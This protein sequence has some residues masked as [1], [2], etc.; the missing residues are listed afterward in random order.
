[1]ATVERL[2]FSGYV[3]T[4]ARVADLIRKM[5]I[6]IQARGSGVGSVL[7]YALHTSSVE[8]IA[9]GLLFERFLSPE[10]QYLPDID[11][12]VESARRHDIYR[13]VFDFFGADR[14]SLMS[15]TNAY[16]GRGAVRDAGLAMGLSGD[17]IDAIPK[18][19]WRFNARDFRRALV[20]KP[21]LAELA[22]DVRRSEHL[23][24]LVD[25]TAK[26]DRLP[27]HFSVRPAGSSSPTHRCRTAPGCRRPGWGCP[28]P[29]S[30][31][32]TWTRWA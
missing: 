30:T 32:T 6:R 21:E 4:A 8:P 3:L 29:S 27:H 20:E 17:T 9:N 24:L 11:L 28:C 31:N 10:R 7:H 22:A 14:V 12:D 18:Q 1:M 25:L 26:L 16:R 5:G 15:M 23:D 2:G 19:M 13:A